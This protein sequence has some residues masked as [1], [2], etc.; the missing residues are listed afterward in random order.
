MADGDKDV[1]QTDNF[2]ERCTSRVALGLLDVLRI[3]EESRTNTRDMSLWTHT[4][5]GESLS[6]DAIENYFI[7]GRCDDCLVE[8]K[9]RGT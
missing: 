2:M 3:Q 7:H 8:L 9:I 1:K 6:T 5:K 4:Q